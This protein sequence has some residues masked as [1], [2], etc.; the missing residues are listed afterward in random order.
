MFKPIKAAA[1]S[2]RDF[3][4]NRLSRRARRFLGLGIVTGIAVSGVLLANHIIADFSKPMGAPLPTF[5]PRASMSARETLVSP[6]EEN[7]EEVR[8]QPEAMSGSP[9]CGG[10]AEMIVLLVGSDARADTYQQGL[11]DTIRVVRLNFVDEH[12]SLMSVPRVLWVSSPS[13]EDYAGRLDGYF[14]SALDPDGGNIDGEGAY[15]TLN[16]AYFYGNLYQVPPAGGPGVLAEALYINLGIPTDHYVAVDMRVVKAAVDAVGGVDIDVPYDV[17]EFSAGLQHMSGDAV[18]SFARTRE[19]DNDWYRIERQDI[20][21]RALW[22]KMSEPRYLAQVPSLADRFLDDILT[23][24]S[25]AQVTSLA[26]LMARLSPEDI[27]TYRISQD[28][29]EVTSTTQGFFILLP[30]QEQ[31]DRLVAEF[32]GIGG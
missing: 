30:R 18:L 32:L 6:I 5:G 12:I 4:R 2:C 8:P 9:V 24:L 26:C 13:L 27:R 28:V 1:Q 11:A 17:A 20:V 31:I 7:T 14:G 19:S 23:D 22:R 3:L 16:S 15:A 29:V 25:K 10:P 21:L